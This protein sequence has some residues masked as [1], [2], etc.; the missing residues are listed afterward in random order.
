[1]YYKQYMEDINTVLHELCD[2][3][4]YRDWNNMFRLLNCDN[5][6]INFIPPCN[7][8]SIMHQVC[9]SDEINVLK[10]LINKYFGSLKYPIHN[11]YGSP[12]NLAPKNG[13]IEN[14]YKTY[15]EYY[16]NYEE[17]LNKEN[18]DDAINILNV[19]PSFITIYDKTGLTIL[20]K[21]NNDID[22]FIKL[23]EIGGSKILF[24]KNST[25]KTVIDDLPK[26]SLILEFINDRI[27]RYIDELI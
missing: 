27:L 21:L 23:Y 2:Y 12:I 5:N 26:D 22:R 3:A 7:R 24:I 16:K 1:M 8:L 14:Y 20:H 19:Y 9:E 6:L 13:L 18:Y 15:D 25:D 4:K 10:T 11:I 17:L